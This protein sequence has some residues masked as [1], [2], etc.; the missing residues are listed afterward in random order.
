[1]TGHGCRLVLM[2]QATARDAEA[3]AAGA[4][5]AAGGAEL[6]V[7]QEVAPACSDL[8]ASLRRPAL[9]LLGAGRELPQ[10]IR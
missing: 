10:I 2:A 8:L 1:M 5:R 7:T 6:A 4:L 9:G 3:S